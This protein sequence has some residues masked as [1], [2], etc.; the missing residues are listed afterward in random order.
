MPLR[1]VSLTDPSFAYDPEDP[2][3]FRSGMHRLGPVL[4]ARHTGV[5]VYELPPGQ[6]LCPFH[7]EY[8][9]EEWLLV[10]AGTATVRHAGGTEDLQTSDI[11]FFGRG[12]DG[13]H[14]V[15]ND[16]D[17]AVRVLMF[18]DVVLPTATAYPDSDKVGL[19]TGN[20]DDDL[21]VRRSSGVG[22]FEGEPD[23]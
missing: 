21:I 8:G 5:S 7:Y 17:E 23:R 2:D 19:W 11:V 16:S 10:L 9:E 14:E 4:G 13:A 18:S 6:A 3:G 20:P 12:P 22:Y 1:R 15:R